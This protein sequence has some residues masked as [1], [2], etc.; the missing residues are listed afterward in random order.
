[1]VNFSLS[2]D[3]NSNDIYFSSYPQ[4]DELFAHIFSGRIKLSYF[5]NLSTQ[6]EEVIR[7]T[8]N[9]IEE[10]DK[11]VPSPNPAVYCVLSIN[12]TL[13]EIIDLETKQQVR[14]KTIDFKRLVD[15]WIK[16]VEV[17][18]TAFNSKNS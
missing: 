1:M 18:T 5:K 9:D 15:N 13:A 2:I 4:K 12:N 17:N 3:L 7:R 14:L 6:L 8:R 16:F 11:V 10:E